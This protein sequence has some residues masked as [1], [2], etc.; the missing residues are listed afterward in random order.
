[1]SPQSLSDDLDYVRQLAEEGAGAPSLSGRFSIMWGT[2]V[3]LALLAHWSVLAGLFP[4][5][6]QWIG[7][8][9]M[10][11]AIL[12]VTGSAILSATLRDKPGKSA[13]GNRADRAV[14][15]AATAGIFLYAVSVA[16]AVILRDM[17]ILL[18][19]TIIPAAF[20]TYAIGKAVSASLFRDSGRKPLVYLSLGLVAVSMLLVGRPEVYLIAAAG[21]FILHVVPGYFEMR[22]EPSDV[23]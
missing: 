4:L 16:A 21:V 2:L 17:P 10:T 13:P 14:W 20:L 18:F 5:E 19:D 23:V 8:I 3:M 22:A 15:P 9:W 11:M 7:A 12:G 6:Q 1:M